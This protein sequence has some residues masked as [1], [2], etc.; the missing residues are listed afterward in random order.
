MGGFIFPTKKKPVGITI[1]RQKVQTSPILKNPYFFKEVIVYY[2][3]DR[4]LTHQLKA[5]K[6]DDFWTAP[7][8]GSTIY[9]SQ[10][11]H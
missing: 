9:I 1:V 3:I 8:K 10:S 7:T 11:L 6:L 2:L 4:Q 5:D